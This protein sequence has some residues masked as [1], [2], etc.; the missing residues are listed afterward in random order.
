MAVR[1]AT[2]STTIKAFV[3]GF[4]VL[5]LMIPLTLLRGLVS[6]RESRRSDAFAR[7]AEGWGGELTL[8]GPL[9]VIPIQRTIA[10]VGR[11]RTVHNRLYLLPAELDVT[12]QVLIQPE[13]RRVGIYE[14]PVYLAE[15]GLTGRFDFASVAARSLPAGTELLWAEA[16]IVLPLSA[17]R[18]L[19]EVRRAQ[20][21]GQTLHLSPASGLVVSG[22]E[23]PVDLS[24]FAEGGVAA[25]DFD[26]AA[27]GSRAFSVLPL[28]SITSATVHS[29]WAHP[30][31]R[32]AFLPTR[33]T[34]DSDGFEAEW[35][36]LELNRPFGHTWLEDDPA[37]TQLAST[38]FGVGIHAVVDIY[39]R[40]ERAIKYAV[41][42]LALT[43]LTFFA[44]EQLGRARIHPLQYLLVGLALSVF[45][46]LLIALAEHIAFGAAYGIAAS[47]LVLLIG[48]YIAGALGSGRRGF[49]AGTLM[50]ATYGVLYVL[51]LSEDYALLL[52]AIAVFAALAAVMLITRKID[53]YRSGPAGE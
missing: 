31:F 50:A 18:S 10:E 41:L 27:A 4:I 39:Q 20:L 16:R 33:R 15:A 37:G 13:P 26:F 32:G 21:H 22:V 52:G 34:I 42:F 40:G 11:E 5:L 53:W 9:V 29:N 44:W 35:R 6:E 51:L 23:A 48:C 36:V 30:S 17:A 7:V 47:A 46:L 3:V 25:F 2:G 28:G 38:A 12:A 43:F 45:Y 8:G 14:V 49:V 24:A 19:R 1:I